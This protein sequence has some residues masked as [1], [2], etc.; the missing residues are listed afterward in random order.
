V[1]RTF[2]QRLTRGAEDVIGVENT[3]ATAL[4]WPGDVWEG[5]ADELRWH[6]HPHAAVRL[7]LEAFVTMA[8]KRADPHE[9]RPAATVM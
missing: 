8:R 9:P 3:R 1:L 5:F 6:L 2:T 7:T 4:S